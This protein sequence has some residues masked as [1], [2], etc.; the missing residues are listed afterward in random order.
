M[1]TE[2]SLQLAEKSVQAAIAAIEIYNKP[3][4]SYREEA[5]AILMINA[6]E[7]LLKGKWVKSNNE[8]HEALF[9]RTKN[10]NGEIVI[11]TNRSGNQLSYGAT[12]LL[13]KF[14]EDKTSGV[15][16]ACSDNFFA[17]LEIRDNAAHFVNKDLY[18]GRRILE[19]GT[20]SLKNYL[21]LATDWFALDLSK[22]NFFLMPISFFH[23]FESVEPATRAHYPMQV[24]KLLEYLD[25]VEAANDAGPIGRQNVTLKLE[26]KLVRGK[27]EAAVEFQ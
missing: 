16:K 4:F 7:L 13:S 24:Q 6:W 27:G 8:R 23:G 2:L 17:L 3:S 12:F 19:I 14:L 25:G 1:P 20:A 15:E 22:Y 11:K 26:T 10:S 5:F 21:L 9:E 18:L